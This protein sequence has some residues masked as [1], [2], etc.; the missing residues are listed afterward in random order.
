MG[1]SS[2]VVASQRDSQTVYTSS[3]K[4]IVSS[5]IKSMPVEVVPSPAESTATNGASEVSDFDGERGGY[6]S[7]YSNIFSP[8]ETTKLSE[9]N[10]MLINKGEKTPHTLKKRPTNMMCYK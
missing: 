10:I 8:L 6:N 5:K 7:D 9:E 1:G 4:S 2:T 3:Y